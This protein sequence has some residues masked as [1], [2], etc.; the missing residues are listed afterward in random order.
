MAK[1]HMDSLTKQPHRKAL[2]LALENLPPELDETYNDALARIRNQDKEDA[3]IAHQVLGWVTHATRPL[4]M[5]QLQHALSVEPGQDD[6]DEET[7]I[8]EEL[9]ISTCLGLVTVDDTSEEVR[10]VH[11]TA[12][13]YFEHK[14]LE[15]IPDN[16]LRIASTCLTYVS[17][18]AC[19]GIDEFTSDEE[20][21]ALGD[22]YALLD[23]AGSN[24]GVHAQRGDQKLVQQILCFLSPKATYLSS[25]LMIGGFKS[26]IEESTHKHWD[27][28]IKYE[29]RVSGHNMAAYFGLQHTLITLL[30]EA[31]CINRLNDMFKSAL[32]ICSAKGNHTLVQLLLDC[33]ANT[34]ACSWMGY[35]AL[36]LTFLNKDVTSM[37]VLLD[38]GADINAV[39]LDSQWLSNSGESILYEF[40][41]T[42]LFD[43]MNQQQEAITKMLLDR[44][45]DV[46]VGDPTPLCRAVSDRSGQMVSLLISNG[47]DLRH[48][49]NIEILKLLIGKRLIYR[50]SGKFASENLLG[51]ALVVVANSLE[52]ANVAEILINTGADI[53]FL[54]IDKSIQF[55]LSS[56]ACY[57]H[58]EATQWLNGSVKWEKP[59][60]DFPLLAASRKG[61]ESLVRVL[62]DRGARMWGV[63]E[64]SWLQQAKFAKPRA[65]EPVEG[66]YA[67]GVC[68]SDALRI[69]YRKII[70]SRDFEEVFRENGYAEEWKK[71]S[72]QESAILEG[73]QDSDLSPD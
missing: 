43:A 67:A 20:I 49:G 22:R 35:T 28:P 72:Q 36:R 65:I 61:N 3:N 21:T 23:Y 44:G 32:L 58:Q 57:N 34:D 18:N 38:G 46:N 10:L 60:L 69:S 48:P 14:L 24:W 39:H 4:T 6:L 53:N 31:T 64:E 19:Q 45:A 56:S 55:L 5:K 15:L 1:L 26:L 2:R 68:S 47:A 33:G 42:I 8:D 41:T 52:P 16:H 40:R 37:N 51:E 11:Y 30:A 66:S 63:E 17:F 70:S 62:L 54:S 50:S 27:Y 29:A 25:R 9:L 73:Q 12:Q 59:L 71:F 7:L 13:K